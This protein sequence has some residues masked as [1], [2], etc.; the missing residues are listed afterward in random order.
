MLARALGRRGVHRYRGGRGCHRGGPR[1]C[2][3]PQGG[4]RDR[5]RRSSRNSPAP[6]RAPMPSR[7]SSPSVEHS[8]TV[9]PA[10]ESVLVVRAPKVAQ[11][12]VEILDRV[13]R[14]GR[15]GA[16]HYGTRQKEA[17]RPRDGCGGR[18]ADGLYLPA[19]M[20]FSRRQLD[21]YFPRVLTGAG[22]SRYVVHVRTAPARLISASTRWRRLSPNSP[23]TPTAR[24]AAAVLWD[25]RKDNAGGDAP[26]VNHLW[27]RVRGRARFISRRQSARTTCTPHGRSTHSRCGCCRRRCA[28][29]VARRAGLEI[30]LGDLVT[31]SESA[32]I[33]SDCWA[34]RRARRRRALRAR[35]DAAHFATRTRAGA[36]SSASH[37]PHRVRARKPVGRAHRDLFR[38]DRG[39]CREPPRP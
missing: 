16:T 21:E 15:E 39:A 13:M 25:P 9:L 34:G 1:E 31:V 4:P 5:S 20:P 14:F 37:R 36:S 38:R 22:V 12:W 11:A 23:P 32:H 33:Y 18:G 8:P 6:K 7:E 2:D 27:A 24:S 29:E 26:C 17:A 10:A 28:R 19:Y 30:G 3:A 35:G